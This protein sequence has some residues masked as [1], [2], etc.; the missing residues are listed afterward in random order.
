MTCTCEFRNPKGTATSVIIRE[1]RLLLVKRNQE[2]FKGA[3]DLC[4]GYMQEGETP[5]QTIRR[6][7]KEELGVE[8]T[9]ATRIKD[10]PGVAKWKDS[11]NP[12]ISHVFLVDFEGQINLDGE[13]S[14]FAWYPLKDLNPEDISF[15]SNQR[16]VARV[17]ENWTYDLD[18]VKELVRQ[19]DPAAE[20]KEQ[21]LY[22]A[23]LNGYVSRIYDRFDPSKPNGYENGKLIAMGWIYPRQTLLRNQA[24]IEDMIVDEL[25]RGK[26]LG[27]AILQDLIQWAREKKIE[28]IELTTGHHR[29]AAGKLYESEGF[30]IHD[31]KHMLLNL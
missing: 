26:G 15:D 6:E 10:F 18:R 16:I 22:K 13:N 28:V 12:I 29:I 19:L 2:P 23:T 31:T 25:Y 5:E 24:V 14:D 1:N 7:V 11:L 21:N 8:V 4:G 9:E 20:I 27:R 30:K 17:K 3:W